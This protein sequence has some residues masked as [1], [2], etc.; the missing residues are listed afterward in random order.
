MLLCSMGGLSEFVEPMMARL[1]SRLPAEKEWEFEV[2]LD[3]IRAIGIKH[4]KV[5]HLFSRR[6]RE[7]TGDFP[8]IVQA[9]ARLPVKRCIVDGEIV[10]FDGEGRTSFQILQ[11]RG[12]E[13]IDT[14][15]ILFDL[16]Q[17]DGK[18][19][20]KEPLAGR[21]TK[22]EKLLAKANDPLRFSGSFRASPEK[23]WKEVKR[24]G[25]EGVIAKRVDSEY[26][27]GRRSGAWVKVKAQNEQEF[28]IGGYTPPQG[29]RKHF[30]SI[31]VGYYEN[32]KFMFASGVGSGFTHRSLETLFKTFQK[33]KTADCPFANLP[34]PKPR[35][36][37]SKADMRRAT[38]LEPKLVCQ[39]KFYEWTRDGN[40]R[41]PVFLG[42]REDKKAAEVVREKMA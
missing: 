7:L 15:Y 23:I 42:L 5:V 20:L 11:N 25:L 39:V 9:I 18:S 35:G 10:A 6:P 4:D 40:L 30:G 33:L 28:V 36:G 26:E 32:G 8:G 17:L 3:G 16:I 27:P 13:T 37:F 38:W 2:K 1:Q 29:S 24:L 34:W 14:Y 31:L 12:Q 22:L 41:Q 19:L 21:R